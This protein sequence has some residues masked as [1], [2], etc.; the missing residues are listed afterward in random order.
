ML[1]QKPIFPESPYSV[2]PRLKRKPLPKLVLYFVVFDLIITLFIGGGALAAWKLGWFQP[3]DP[4]TRQAMKTPIPETPTAISTPTDFPTAVLASTA[5]PAP[6]TTLPASDRFQNPLIPYEAVVKI[7]VMVASGDGDMEGWWG[8]GTLISADGLIL[9]NAHVVSSTSDFRVTDLVIALNTAADL[10]PEPRYHARIVQ[11][12][13]ALDVA[14]LRISTDLDGNVVNPSALTLPFVPL[15][16]SD[17]LQLGDVLVILG[18]P[19]IGGA[20]ITL[21]RGEVSGFT[22]LD[23]AQGVG[24]NDAGR[25]AYIKTTAVIT[26]GTSGGLAANNIGELVGIAPRLGNGADEDYADCRR[27][28]DTNED[29]VIDENDSCIPAGGFINALRPINLFKP[30]I[31]AAERGEVN[32]VQMVSEERY[33]VLTGERLYFDDFSDPASGWLQDRGEERSFLYRDGEYQIEVNSPNYSALLGLGLSYY[34]TIVNVDAHTDGQTGDSG[35]GIICRRQDDANYYGFEISEDGYFSIWKREGGVYTF[36]AY[37][38][39]SSLIANVSSS[40]ALSEMAHLTAACVSDKLTLAV[41]DRIL[42]EVQ[43]DTFQYGDVGLFVNT[44]ANNEV[45]AVFDN[46]SVYEP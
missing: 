20:T 36:L 1:D 6:Q 18:Y 7:V 22:P 16:N 19:E 30:Y 25:R 44:Y 26:G 9:T 39:Y 15:G 46:F 42:V 41:N 35:Y 21:T 28:A 45:V 31:E 32:Y 2:Q 29:G 33:Y 17:C 13:R 11:I 5:Q 4:S 38:Q 12:D 40:T 37:W 8:S 3:S 24:E 34:D 23:A 10:P 14:V 43:D 27:L